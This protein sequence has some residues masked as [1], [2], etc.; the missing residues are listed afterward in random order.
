MEA[1]LLDPLTLE[2][3]PIPLNLLPRLP[4]PTVRADEEQASGLLEIVV[5]QALRNG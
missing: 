5:P 1:T 3:L 2:P 4:S